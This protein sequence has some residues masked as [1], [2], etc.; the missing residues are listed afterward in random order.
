[1]RATSILGSLRLE[2]SLRRFPLNQIALGFLH[3]LVFHSC[4]YANAMPHYR[5]A[6]QSSRF[7]VLGDLV[8]LVVRGSWRKKFGLVQ[9]ISVSRPSSVLPKFVTTYVFRTSSLLL[10]HSKRKATAAICLYLGICAKGKSIAL[11]SGVSNSALI[12]RGA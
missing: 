7:E 1:M 3:G 8:L 11:R 2:R 10:P 5:E 9:L 6:N 4:Q 12:P